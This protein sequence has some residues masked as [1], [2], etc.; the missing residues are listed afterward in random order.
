MGYVLVEWGTDADGD[1]LTQNLIVGSNTYTVPIG[2]KLIQLNEAN[3]ANLTA[4]AFTNDGMIDSDITSRTILLTNPSWTD[5]IT[6]NQT[7][8]KA[9]HFTELRTKINQLEDYYGLENTVWGNEISSGGVVRAADVIEMRKALERI[10]N[11]LNS[12]G[13]NIAL[14]WT[15]STLTNKR[16]KAIHI[17]E[18]RTA[19]TTL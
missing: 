12:Y 17:N 3:Y 1:T 19:L 10:A 7:M 15:D 4:Q 9:I 16:I 13:A 5:T 6:K 8:V 11:F 14:N 2:I 18:L